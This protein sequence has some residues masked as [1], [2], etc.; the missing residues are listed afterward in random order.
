MSHSIR[1]GA[2][3]FTPICRHGYSKFSNALDDTVSA[4]RLPF[5]LATKRCVSL[6]MISVTSDDFCRI[7][8]TVFAW[9]AHNFAHT[10]QR[11]PANFGA[12]I[13]VST[14]AAS[15]RVAVSFERKIVFH[16]VSIFGLFCDNI[17]LHNCIAC[18]AK[19]AKCHYFRVLPQLVRLF[20]S[21]AR[22]K[23]QK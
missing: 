8:A 20:V 5:N 6:P 10:F 13:G 1:C 15:Q 9:F 2:S 17:L 21:L 14:F 4:D 18:V 12:K 11:S 3:S 22:G 23:C 16:I 19:F 7:D